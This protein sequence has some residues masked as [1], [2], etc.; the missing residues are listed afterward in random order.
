MDARAI[1]V[2]CLQD[3]LHREGAELDQASTR[4][5]VTLDQV[6]H[7]LGGGVL[8]RQQAQAISAPCGLHDLPQYLDQ[9]DDDQQEGSA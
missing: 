7:L 9:Q 6:N 3:R 1:L 4:R 2:E 5:T 8:V